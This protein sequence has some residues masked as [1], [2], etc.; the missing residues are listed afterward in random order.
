MN[1]RRRRQD[2]A[3]TGAP[4]EAVGGTWG[5]PGH[6]R[7][8]WADRPSAGDPWAEPGEARDPWDSPDVADGSWGEAD[9][10]IDQVAGERAGSAA[11]GPTG[12]WGPDDPWS[13]DDVT[14]A[15]PV[16]GGDPIERVCPYL[17]SADGAWR[18]TAPHADHRCTSQSPAVPVPTLAQERFCLTSTHV[19]CEWYAEATATREAALLRDH[20]DVERLDAARFQPI[21]RSVPV[22]LDPVS[23]APERPT[24]VRL[25]LDRRSRRT[26]IGA[27]VAVAGLAVVLVLAGSG[28]PGP[29]GPLVGGGNGQTGEPVA[30]PTLGPLPEPTPEVVPAT[31]TPEPTPLLVEYEVREG[32]RLRDI[33]QGFGVRRRDVVALNDLGD[34]PRVTAGQRIVIPF[35][36]GSTPPPGSDPLVEAP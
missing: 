23:G 16:A 10:P 33:V 34:P 32:E 12:D 9:A 15:V 1:V 17:R 18:S 3:P 24:G 6:P 14:S 8:P 13:L 36:P 7:D 2:D 30:S 29:D 27:L 5:E 31:A 25:R 21:V 28:G 4:G 11:E 26:A 20:I 35:P 22:M 19:R